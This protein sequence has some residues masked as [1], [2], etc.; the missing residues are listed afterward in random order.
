MLGSVIDMDGLG[1]ESQDSAVNQDLL[2]TITEIGPVLVRDSNELAETHQEVGMG[3]PTN[4]LRIRLGHQYNSLKSRL[5]KLG[6]DEYL[7]T[8]SSPWDNSLEI[9][10]SANVLPQEVAFRTNTVTLLSSGF[11]LLQGNDSYE[12]EFFDHLDSAFPAQFSSSAEPARA[13]DLAFRIRCQQFG[14]K[15]QAADKPEK[16]AIVAARIFCDAEYKNVPSAIQRLSN[17]PYRPFLGLEPSD[18]QALERIYQESMQTLVSQVLKGRT[19]QSVL[20]SLEDLCPKETL[21][22]DLRTWALETYSQFS[23]S[24][25]PAES[26]VLS[27]AADLSAHDDIVVAPENDDKSDFEDDS[28]SEDDMAP[29]IIYQEANGPEQ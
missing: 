8:S 2:D 3:V 7:D 24:Q 6:E 22:R 23:L 19:L 11:E 10:Q 1:A 21:L 27:D 18:S 4:R 26:E 12:G 16:A 25:A 5:G 29:A 9:S 28:D 13:L 20:N 14:A 17:G 15:L